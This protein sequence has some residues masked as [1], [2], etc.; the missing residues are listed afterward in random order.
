MGKQTVIVSFI[1]A[2]SGGFGLILK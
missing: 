1:Q 2:V